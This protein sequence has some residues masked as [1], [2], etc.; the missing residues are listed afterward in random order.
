MIKVFLSML[1]AMSVTA[2]ATTIEFVVPFPPGGGTDFQAS[3]LESAVAESNPN[4]KINKKY[5]NSCSAA[6]SYAQEVSTQN[7]T[8]F[9][10]DV[11][12][13]ILG[14]SSKGSRCP[15]TNTLTTTVTPI[16]KLGSIPLFLCASPKNSANMTELLQKPKIVVGYAATASINAVAKHLNNSQYLMVPYQGAAAVKTAVDSGEA[17]MFLGANFAV[18]YINQGAKCVA[19]SSNSK[20][21]QLPSLGE[22]FKKPVPTWDVTTVLFRVGNQTNTVEQ[23]V[24]A[25]KGK[26]FSAALSTRGLYNHATINEDVLKS[27]VLQEKVLLDS[28]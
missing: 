15:P 12:D 8:Y 16:T 25:A 23:V 4:I 26:S 7:P 6:L 10:A 19:I 17:D 14:D 5:F 3:S 21:M 28:N 24:R 1:L 11:G 27:I 13:I 18:P 20:V 2:N 9:F 22:F